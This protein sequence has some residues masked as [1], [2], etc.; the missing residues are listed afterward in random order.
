MTD[1]IQ[2]TDK[3]FTS[4]LSYRDPSGFVFEESG[5][6]YR[7]VNKNFQEHFDYFIKSG[8]YERLVKTGLLIPHETL[9]DPPRTSEGYLVLKPERIPF[10]SYPYEWSF[11]MLKDAALLTLRLLREALAHDMILKDASPYNIQWYKG[12]LV[13]IDSLS[14]EKYDEQQPWIAYRQFCESFLA[15]L[16]LMHYRAHPLQQLL[17]AWPEGIPLDITSSLLPWRTRLS[18]HSYLHIHLHANISGRKNRT[19][20]KK[21]IFS[22]KKLLDLVTSLEVLLNRLHLKDR[23]STWS[24]YYDE[25]STRGEYLEHKKRIISSWLLRSESIKMAIDLGAN[26]GIFSNLLAVRNIQTIAADFDPY[27]INRLYLRVKKEAQK[28]IQPLVLDISNPSPSIGFNNEERLSFLERLLTDRLWADLLL[29]LGLVHHLTISK[30]IPFA[31]LARLFSKMGKTLVIEFIP[32][33][34][35]KVKEMLAQKKDIYTHYDEANFESAFR[36][37]FS[38]LNKE[39]IPGSNRVLYLMSAL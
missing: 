6:I 2:P 23:E 4:G 32:K 30:N 36:E 22:R 25:V 27:C 33:E 31:K 37:H 12:R 26:E 38:I 14:F 20:D 11:D 29:A 1:P 21:I 19:A 7:Q 15:P 8:C 28:N 10:I 16:M 18:L 35:I 3:T 5:I 24:G 34:D 9:Q 13:L 17:L 39:Q